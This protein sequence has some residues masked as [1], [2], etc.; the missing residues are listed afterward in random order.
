MF[1]SCMTLSR[2]SFLLSGSLAALPLGAAGSFVRVSRRDSRYLELDDGS[3]YIPIGLNLIAPPGRD[4]DAGLLVY[5]DWL[6]KLSL[7]GGNYVRAWLSNTFWDV[8]HARSGEHDPEKARLIDA[9]LAMARQRKVRRKLPRV[10]SRGS[11]AGP[12]AGPEKPL[13]NAV[14]G[15]PATSIAD[16]FDGEK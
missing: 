1:S 2:R 11:G 9:L 6:D 15:G 3:P 13:H 14:N 4:P 12:Q 8:E 16:F 5:K 10:L 7:N